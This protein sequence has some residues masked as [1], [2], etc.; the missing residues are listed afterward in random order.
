MRSFFARLIYVL[1][2]LGS[3]VSAGAQVLPPPP[4]NLQTTNIAASDSRVVAIGVVQA[5]QDLETRYRPTV[6]VTLAVS[7]T[8]KGKPS[9]SEVITVRGSFGY[10]QKWI[11]SKAKVLFSVPISD[12]GTPLFINL[13]D[14]HA[15]AFNSDLELLDTPVGILR[16]LK[17]KIKA[18]EGASSPARFS[19]PVTD[20]RLVGTV[21][22]NTPWRPHPWPAD[23]P[24]DGHL[25]SYALKEILSKDANL[26]ANGVAALRLFPIAHVDLVKQLLTD[27][28]ASIRESFP[29]S[30]GS[31]FVFFVRKAAVETLRQWKVPFNMPKLEE[32][33]SSP[34]SPPP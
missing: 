17:K 7:Q 15:A 32:H 5:L 34:S 14:P 33:R 2:V 16:D 25:Q 12:H 11:D 23:V 9:Q 8:L 28:S 19:V 18:A 21:L 26:R 10:L 3:V 1:L 13:S 4:P 29:D 24:V 31:D 6:K 30:G 20:E 22:A 27:P